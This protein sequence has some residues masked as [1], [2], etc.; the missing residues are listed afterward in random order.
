M[1]LSG[2]RPI[3]TTRP[4]PPAGGCGIALVAPTLGP[5][6]SVVAATRCG[7]GAEGRSGHG[8]AVGEPSVTGWPGWTA[9]GVCGVNRTPLTNVPLLLPRS[10]T[11][12]VVPRRD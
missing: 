5:A 2:A 7:C 8:S 3:F 9:A 11:D 4:A 6:L 1:S 12:H 10:S